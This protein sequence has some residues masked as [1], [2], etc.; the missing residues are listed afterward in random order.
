MLQRIV[1]NK[2]SCL[3]LLSIFKMDHIQH[4]FPGLS[5]HLNRVAT[6]IPARPLVSDQKNFSVLSVIC[7]LADG[8]ERNISEQRF[9][10]FLGKVL[11][12]TLLCSAAGK[13]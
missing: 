7:S 5:L 3:K 1:L 4:W 8:K 10:L 9:P 2:N 13:E 11:H 12:F 6:D